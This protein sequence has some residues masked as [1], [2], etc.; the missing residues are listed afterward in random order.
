[1][2]KEDKIQEVVNLLKTTEVMFIH[3]GAGMSADSGLPV[4]RGKN[5]IWGQ[6]E[7]E[8]KGD[9]RNIMTP[10]FIQENPIY[11]WKRFA[12]GRK[13]EKLYPPHAGYHILLKWVKEFDLP[14]FAITSNVDSMFQ[15]TGFG[16]EHILEVHGS[17][18]YQ[19]C[20]TPCTQDIW[21]NRPKF[22][23]E[24]PDISF[25]DL[26]KCPHCGELA[27]PNVLIFRDKTFVP[28]RV[29]VQ[30]E[31][32]TNF[33]AENQGK[34]A[35]IFEIGAGNQIKTIRRYTNKFLREFDAQAVRINLHDSEINFPN[36]SLPF[37]AKE[38]LE[39]I[40]NFLIYK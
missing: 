36:I 14:H 16:E 5:G 7:G 19:Q 4:Y 37:K 35:L 20:T 21:E 10:K 3:T 33:L 32:L 39:E 29:I 11:M 34:K 12:R 38:I 1:M 27:R 26:P 8:L 28:T 30:K 24:K 13:R 15:K 9:I 23:P 6:L 31:N 2:D 40:D 17:G 18:F 22:N 25:E